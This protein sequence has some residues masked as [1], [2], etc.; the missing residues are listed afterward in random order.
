MKLLFY[1][2]IFLLFL[3]LMQLSFFDIIF[4]W[5]RIPLFLLGVVVIFTL[6]RGFPQALFMTVPLTLLFD[7]TS[8][9]TVTW[10]SFYAVIFSYGTSFLSRRLLVE[11]RGLGLLLYA[12]V[13]YGGVLLYQFIFFFFIRENV[14]VHTAFPLWALPS[15][16]SLLY[17]FVFSLPIFIGTYFAIKRF[18]E[19]LNL[20]NQKQFLNVR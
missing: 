12:V 7:V 16:E 11:H 9:G 1:R 20:V 8:I 3:V 13:S 4:P 6:V 17:T 15:N 2:I 14:F 18:E 10:F 5:F 19:H